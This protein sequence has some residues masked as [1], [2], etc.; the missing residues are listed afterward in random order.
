MTDL[1]IVS[2]GQW[3]WRTG[4]GFLA[5]FLLTRLLLNGYKLHRSRNADALEDQE[6][7][8]NLR[9]QSTSENANG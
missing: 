1:Q 3:L 8:D 2:S 6:E 4:L 7:N 9:T 5:I